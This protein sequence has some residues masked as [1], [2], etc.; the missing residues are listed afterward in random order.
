MRYGVGLFLAGFCVCASADDWPQWGGPKRDG[1]WRESGILTQFP[2]AGPKIVWRTPVHLGYA[3]PAVASGKVF[4]TDWRLEPGQKIADNP[5]AR[6]RAKGIERVLCLDAATGQQLWK[7]EYP[8]EYS[9]S[10][11]A[12]PRATPTVDGDRVYTLGAMGDLFCLDGKTGK[13]LWSTN[14]VKD[15]AAEVPVWGFAAHPLIDGDKLICLAGGDN[16]HLVIAFDKTT[17]KKL[18]NALNFSGDFGYCPPLIMEFGGKRQLIIW[19]PKAVVA[20]DPDTGRTLWSVPFEVRAALTIPN[21]RKL[22]DDQLFLTCFYNGSLLLRIH[23]D[24]AEVLWKSKARGERPSQTTDLSAIMSTPVI[25]GEYIYGVC[26]YGQ[27]RCIRAATGERIWETMAATRGKLTP[28]KIAE[29]P[30]PDDSERWAHAFIV[31]HEDHYFLFNEQ[32]DLIIAKFSPKGYQEIS[33][34]NILEPTNAMARGRKVV[35]MHPAFADRSV[36]ARNDKE[37]I[38][39]DLGK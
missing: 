29:N 19:H 20:L 13:P 36:F 17:G 31:P 9:I 23:A 37:I 30:E 32:G 24:N 27:L 15:Y 38:R 6:D 18:W 8:V 25:D 12:G 21:P 34:V 5:F 4:V 39:V 28:P 11:A 3:G 22:G 14:F 7:H 10:Y 26:S 16:D 35:W 1:V 33:R 2:A